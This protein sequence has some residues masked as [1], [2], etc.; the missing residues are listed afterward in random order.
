MISELCFEKSSTVL[1]RK[2]YNN[3]SDIINSF[4]YNDSLL[5]RMDLE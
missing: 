4:R 5:Y 1:K 3:S 2:Y